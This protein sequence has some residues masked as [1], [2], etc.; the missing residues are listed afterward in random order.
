MLQLLKERDGLDAVSARLVDVALSSSTDLGRI[1]NDVL[2]FSKIESGKMELESRA[3]SLLDLLNDIYEL[4]LPVAV[5]KGIDFTAEF[6]LAKDG[7]LVAG[8]DY[9]IRQIVSNL[10]GNALKFTDKGFVIMK[11]HMT[12]ECDLILTVTD[13]GIGISPDRHDM[14]FEEFKMLG[15][16]HARKFGGTGL[17]LSICKRLLELMG[18]KIS[19]E[20]SPGEGATFVIGIP[21]GKEAN[22]EI[23]L[24]PSSHCDLVG[25]CLMV[26]DD[27]ETN[28]LVVESLSLIH[29]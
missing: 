9:R 16:T 19:V 8:D 29:I 14:L 3:F 17:G 27:N 11:A 5:Q 1:V 12:S 26:V 28:R 25:K 2:D 23:V 18:G 13:S 22:P 7:K 20:S 24:P 21:L 15:A 4:M 10:V 6:D